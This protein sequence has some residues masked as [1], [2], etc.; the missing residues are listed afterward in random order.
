MT[1]SINR[2]QKLT[3]AASTPVSIASEDPVA[4]S[5]RLRK[6]ST[7]VGSHADSGRSLSGGG[8]GLPS[9][10][11]ALLPSPPSSHQISPMFS[12]CA[13]SCS[14]SCRRPEERFA[15]RGRLASGSVTFRTISSSSDWDARTRKTRRDVRS[16][17]E[18]DA[19]DSTAI[20]R[21]KNPTNFSGVSALSRNGAQTST[22][23]R[24]FSFTIAIMDITCVCEARLGLKCGQRYDSR[25][26][27][28][29]NS[30]TRCSWGAW[31]PPPSSST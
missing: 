21:R 10:A 30:C 15:H 12:S 22:P 17:V 23:S 29:S 8:A 18:S 5:H 16:R 20:T 9:F 4:R 26:C 27:E 6:S 2:S 31:S 11:A 25:Y 14:S 28:I 19:S 24:R 3:A 1:N 7:R 13:L